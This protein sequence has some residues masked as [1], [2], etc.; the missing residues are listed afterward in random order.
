MDERTWNI[1]GVA[2]FALAM[3]VIIG[4]VAGYDP[5]ALVFR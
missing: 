3:A 2:T 4:V 5:T 1:I